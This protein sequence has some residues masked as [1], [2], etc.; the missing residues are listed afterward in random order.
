MESLKKAL[1]WMDMLCWYRPF[2]SKIQQADIGK[3]DHNIKIA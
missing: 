2:L 3:H 1:L